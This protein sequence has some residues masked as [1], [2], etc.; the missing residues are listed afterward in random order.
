MISKK[1]NS[2]YVFLLIGAVVLFSSFRKKTVTQKSVISQTGYP[3]GQRLIL[4]VPGATIYDRNFSIVWVNDT[5]SYVEMS[6]LD[7]T[8]DTYNVIYGMN[9]QNGLPAIIFKSDTVTS[10]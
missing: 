7:E 1:N 4:A 9:F 3:A 5:N 6:V 2:L 10:I 8:A